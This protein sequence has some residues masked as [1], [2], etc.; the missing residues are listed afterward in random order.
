[1]TTINFKMSQ[2]SSAKVAPI[3]TRTMSSVQLNI[4]SFLYPEELEWLHPSANYRADFC[5][6]DESCV[7]N[8]NGLILHGSRAA[9]HEKWQFGG[10]FLTSYLPKMMHWFIF[11]NLRLVE[12][13][14]VI[15]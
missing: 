8:S 3:A 7:L 12:Y 13:A 6:S 5:L 4:Y 15:R 10:S 9:F 2:R 11:K 1:M 14:F